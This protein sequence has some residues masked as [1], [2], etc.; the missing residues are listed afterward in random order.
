MQQKKSSLSQRNDIRKGAQAG[1]YGDLRLLALC[2]GILL[3][4]AAGVLFRGAAAPQRDDVRSSPASVDS[5]LAE[6]EAPVQQSSVE[7]ADEYAFEQAPDAPLAIQASPE[8]R[9]AGIQN[10]IEQMPRNETI[11]F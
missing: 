2:T 6:R 10:M 5:G 7:A 3:L 4:C 8:R 11:I 1:R 9:D